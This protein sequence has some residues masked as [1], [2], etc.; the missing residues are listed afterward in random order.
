MAKESTVLNQVDQAHPTP[1][2]SFLVQPELVRGCVET[3]STKVDRFF[4]VLYKD[5][6]VDQLWEVDGYRM[7]PV[8]APDDDSHL[9]WTFHITCPKCRNNLL[10]DSTKKKIQVYRECGIESEVFRCG[11]PAQFGGPCPFGVALELPRKR[12]ERTVVIE[13]GRIVKVDAVAKRI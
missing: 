5:T 2:S 9:T 8:Q 13:G 11:H 6:D 4:Y 12:E 7:G 1:R 10:L 3:K